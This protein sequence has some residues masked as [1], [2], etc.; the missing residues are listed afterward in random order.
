MACLTLQF[1]QNRY[2]GLCH[3]T[4]FYHDPGRKRQI[5]VQPAAEAD[6]AVSSPPF[7]TVAYL[8]VA[9]DA[10][11][12]QACDLDDGEIGCGI[13]TA[14]WPDTCGH[15]LIVHARLGER[16]VEET[17]VP[18][19]KRNDFAADRHPVH[20]DSEDIHEDR[21]ALAR[22]TAKLEFFRRCRLD[23]GKQ[24]SIGGTD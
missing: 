11:R 20:M 4:F 7:D 19:G 2:A 23:D 18:I 21:E 12:D 13:K 24:H 16:G 1:R 17:P 3:G 5:D 22:L 8:E 6:H 15:S 10:T 9:D 14:G